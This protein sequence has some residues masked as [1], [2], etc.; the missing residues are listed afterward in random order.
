MPKNNIDDF[1]TEDKVQVSM[2]FWKFKDK[3]EVIGFFD[4]W[5]TDN[6]GNHAVLLVND[7]KVHLPNLTALNGKLRTGKAIE[8]NKI[9]IVYLGQKKAKSGRVYEDFDVSIK[10]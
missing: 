3:K 10:H 5:E 1:T 2:D 8:G 6:Y 7:V 4:G 9:K